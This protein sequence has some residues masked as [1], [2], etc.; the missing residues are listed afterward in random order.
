[1]VLNLQRVINDLLNSFHPRIHLCHES[2]NALHSSI[3]A[4]NDLPKR[5]VIKHREP[6]ISEPVKSATCRGNSVG[7]LEGLLKSP[8]SGSDSDSHLLCYFTPRSPGRAERHDPSGIHRPFRTTEANSSRNSRSQARTH[9]RPQQFALKFRNTRKN[10]EDQTPI[11]G[12]GI[13]AF[14]NG[15]EVDPQRTKFFH[16]IH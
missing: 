3:A 11:W 9:P 16:R 14:M 8:D 1:M 10:S 13:N 6:P 7:F 15:N 5:N 12:A 2:A 4:Q